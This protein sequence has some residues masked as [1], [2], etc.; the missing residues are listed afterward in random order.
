MLSILIPV[1]N[2]N[3]TAL[4]KELHRQ[5]VSLS[6]NFEIICMDDASSLY[7]EENKK[8][9]LLDK[10]QWIEVKIN[11]GRSEIRNALIEAS[12]YDYLLFLDCDMQIPNQQFLAKYSK[13]RENR[14]IC[15]GRIYIDSD[16]NND[17]GLHFHYGKK[18]ETFKTASSLSESSFISGNFFIHKQVFKTVKFNAD[19]KGYGHEDTLFG[20]ELREAG[21]AIL[22]TDNPT[23][24]RGVDNNDSFLD[25]TRNAIDNLFQDNPEIEQKLHRN[26]RLT[27]FAFRYSWLLYSSGIIYPWIK[28]ILETGMKAFPSY[29][30]L[31]DIYKLSYLGNQCLKRQKAVQALPI[32][33]K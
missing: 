4:V 29:I 8:V 13:L 6:V 27:Q 19:I 28:R 20:I 17:T 2:R 24:H 26:V 16:L 3:I 32:S 12:S 9:Q 25:K 11:Q 10:V 15:G 22:F 5:A 1:Y 33:N 7:I 14:V 23:I 31:M 18:R 21:I 30:C